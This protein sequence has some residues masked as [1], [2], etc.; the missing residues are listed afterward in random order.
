MS[1][2]CGFIGIAAV[3]DKNNSLSFLSEQNEKLILTKLEEMKDE[4][5]YLNFWHHLA[6]HPLLDIQQH[7]S[8]KLYELFS[9]REELVEECVQTVW[10][11]F[12]RLWQQS[13][14]DDDFQMKYIHL[15]KSKDELSSVSNVKILYEKEEYVD[16]N[17]WSYSLVRNLAHFFKATLKRELLQVAYQIRNQKKNAQNALDVC[18]DEE[19]LVMSVLGSV[20]NSLLRRYYGGNLKD[21]RRSCLLQIMKQILINYY[22][23]PNALHGQNVPQRLLY[24]NRGGLRLVNKRF[25]EHG[26]RTLDLVAKKIK[27]ENVLTKNAG[28]LKPFVKDIE[29]QLNDNSS[30]E[31]LFDEQK[32]LEQVQRFE[33]SKA[34]TDS[35]KKLNDQQQKVMVLEALKKVEAEFNRAIVTRLLWAYIKKLQPVGKSLR[36][37][38]RL[39]IFHLAAHKPKS[40]LQTN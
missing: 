12:I 27:D 35:T 25:F 11:E 19:Y 7:F 22:K 16:W 5:L 20:A 14:S 29:N 1:I 18:K 13:R 3:N 38:A 2:L 17:L 30:F 31:L 40:S 28:N 15:T 21:F 23:D 6:E 26:K 36:L 9:L 37:R 39:Q 34:T 24:E 32:I 4:S 10:N 33:S 8:D